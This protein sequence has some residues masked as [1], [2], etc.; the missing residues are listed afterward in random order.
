MPGQPV[1]FEIPAQ[2]TSRSRQFW[3]S[4]FGWEWQTI[5]GPFEYHMTRLSDTS[6]A[7]VYP[8]Q[9]GEQGIRVYF[10]ADDINATA[11]RVREIGGEAEEVQPVPGMGWFAICK[12]T[13][14]NPFG[15]WQN[16]PN[17]GGDAQQA[18]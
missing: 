14:G 15:L 5:E 17:A 2:D 8:P 10:D 9:G 11:A 6:G 13:E 1:H 4:L 12:D 18:S 7:A 16:D 3:S